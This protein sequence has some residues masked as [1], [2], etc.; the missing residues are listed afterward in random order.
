MDPYPNHNFSAHTPVSPALS[1]WPDFARLFQPQV[2]RQLTSVVNYGGRITDDKDMRTSD[3]IIAG[4]YNPEI[5]SKDFSFSR[6]GRW[7]NGSV[8][9][10]ILSSLLFLDAMILLTTSPDAHHRER[11][12]HKIRRYHG[13]RP[14]PDIPLTK[15]KYSPF[16]ME[17]R[18]RER[19]ATC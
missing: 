19:L 17:F 9:L 3:I 11:C 15:L 7:V 10:Q 16:V 13:L 1:P 8:L 12:C 5:L 18:L 2:L 14:Y 4:F 6:S